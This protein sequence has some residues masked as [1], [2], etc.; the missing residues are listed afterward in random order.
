MSDK[1]G[2][3]KSVWTK[4]FSCITAAA[5]LSAIG[6]EAMN[7]PISMLVFDRTRSTFMSAA[8][9]VC[10]MLPDILLPVIAAPFIDKGNKKNWIVGLDAFM[11]IVY[12][13]MGLWVM[14]HPFSYWLYICFVL[15]VAADSTL[16]Q[17]AY[18]AWYP[19]LIPA[20]LEQKGYAVDSSVYP[21]VVI[22]MAPV[23]TFLYARA[24]MGYI[25]IAVAFLTLMSVIAEGCITSPGRSE[26]GHYGLKQYA[27]D[28]REGFRYVKNEKGIR[29]IYTYMS[30]T[31]G[32]SDGVNVI[33]Q[34]YYQTQPYLSV[35][36]LGFLK[37]AEMA[38]R[39]ISGFINYF[40]EIPRKKRYRFTKGVY[41][42]YDSMDALL[43][44]MPYPLMLMNRFVCGGLGT[45]S[46]TV[47]QTAVQSYIPEKIRAR[48]NALFAVIFS[49]GGISF[50]LL[51]GALGQIMPYRCAA[52]LLG[53]ITLIC[54][55]IFIVLPAGE[56]APVYESE[57]KA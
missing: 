38:G 5:V 47:R 28:I 2:R 20:G 29:N 35:T 34:A 44:F 17:L 12:T 23:S 40:R 26:S 15:I 3:V 16:Y 31:N 32:V 52:F 37:S 1:A 19:D 39:V 49:V 7:L 55:F 21:V 25:F 18:Q 57:R 22:V 8:V 24:S 45:A 9:M 50:Q 6:G 56:N 43:L 27:D 54:M 51:A 42:F 33:T 53:I 13:A 46:A 10:G 30:I 4:D 48:V 36:M 14:G 11:I 41:M